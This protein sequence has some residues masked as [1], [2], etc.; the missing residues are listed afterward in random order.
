M[1]APPPK[2]PN[3]DYVCIGT[4]N[5]PMWKRDAYQEYNDGH[6]AGAVRFDISVVADKEAS[7][8]LTLPSAKQFQ[9]QVGEVRMLLAFCSI[10][11][12][13]ALAFCSILNVPFCSFFAL[14]FCIM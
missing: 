1:Q 2:N 5:M 10:L 7:L 9:R 14:L 4:W 6:I 3:N 8:G 11:L 12:H 13:F